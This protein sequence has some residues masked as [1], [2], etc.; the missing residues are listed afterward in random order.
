MQMTNDETVMRYRQAKNRGEQIGILAEL[1]ACTEEEII[2]ALKAGGIDGRSIANGR[3]RK[4]SVKANT[5]AELLGQ[6][7]PDFT[8]LSA[9]VAY[10]VEQRRA[11]DKEMQELRAAMQKLIDSMAD[12]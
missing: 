9:R 10:L 6:E 12:A 4:K 11:I 8:V 5:A 3:R 7:K 2:A 1:N